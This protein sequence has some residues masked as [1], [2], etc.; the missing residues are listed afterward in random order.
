MS[1]TATSLKDF[2]AVFP[3]LMSD[4]KEDCKQYNLPDQALNWFEAVSQM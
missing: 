1:F 4:L 3:K 2:E